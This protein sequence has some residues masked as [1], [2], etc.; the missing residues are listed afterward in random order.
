MKTMRKS[1]RMERMMTR[2]RKRKMQTQT[3][4]RV[5]RAKRRRAMKARVMAKRTTG[6]KMPT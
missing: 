5:V 4:L 3:I 1:P 2:R 6:V